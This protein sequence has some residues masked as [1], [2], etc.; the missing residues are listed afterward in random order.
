MAAGVEAGRLISTDV[1]VLHLHYA[2][3][4]HHWFDRSQ[5]Y[6]EEI[7]GQKGEEFCRMWEF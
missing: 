3:I 6:R 7:R 5:R 1:E 2:R 4:L